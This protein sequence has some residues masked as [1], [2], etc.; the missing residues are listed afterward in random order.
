MIAINNELNETTWQSEFIAMLPEIQQ[1]L[2]LAF[3]RLDAEAREDAIEEGIV[4]SLLGMIKAE[5][6]FQPHRVWLGTA[7]DM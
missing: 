2:R 6:R 5:R 4:H 1:K 7:H 3:C